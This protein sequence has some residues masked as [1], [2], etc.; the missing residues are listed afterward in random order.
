MKIGR[1]VIG[2]WAKEM[3]NKN[4][5]LSSI[6]FKSPYLLQISF[7]ISFKIIYYISR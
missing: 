4:Q 1:I 7:T 6:S 5:K 2:R 3:H